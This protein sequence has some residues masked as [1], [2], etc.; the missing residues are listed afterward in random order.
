MKPKCPEKYRTPLRSR[1]D[2]KNYLLNRKALYS[3]PHQWL[4][5]WT[6]HPYR[7]DLKLENLKRRI[8]EVG[9]G[10]ELPWEDAH[11]WS[12]VPAKYT[13]VDEHLLRWGIEDFLDLIT[14]SDCYNM[15]WSGEKIATDWYIFGEGDD[16]TGICLKTFNGISLETELEWSDIDYKT[17][18]HLYRF[19][20]Q[21]DADFSEGNLLQ[22]VEESAAFAFF[23]NVCEGLETTPKRHARWALDQSGEVDLA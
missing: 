11:W 19:I 10:Q 13:E 3:S 18:K 20:R 8:N 22:I 6:F 2:I 7:A 21:C 12:Q 16:R 14:N 4:F 23:M 9:Y 1:F 5:A 15:L 17:I